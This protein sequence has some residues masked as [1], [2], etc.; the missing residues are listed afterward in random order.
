MPIVV[1]VRFHGV[2]KTYDFDPGNLE[3]RSGDAVIVETA[4]GIEY[5]IAS[6]E[7][8]E[9]PAEKIFG[10]LRPVLR[11][12][13]E[14]DLRIYQ[15]NVVKEGEAYKIA[16]ERIEQHGLDMQLVDV[17]YT[18][19][20]QKIIFYFISEN[21]VDFRELVKDLAITFHRRIELRQI[22]ARDEA[23]MVGGVG[24]CG[25]TFCCS[26]FLDDFVP[27]SVKM[28][29]FQN[30]SMNPTK[31]SGCC[32]RLMCCLKYEQ[33]AYED[34][35]KIAPKQ[36]ST[37]HSPR[38]E[39]RVISV[40][41]LHERANVLVYGP[42]GE[43]IVPF[44]FTELQ[45]QK[46]GHNE[47]LM[48]RRKRGPAKS[49]AQADKQSAP[50]CGNCPS[51]NAKADMQKGA[52]GKAVVGLQ[53][54]ESYTREAMAVISPN[55]DVEIEVFSEATITIEKTDES[56]K[57]RSQRSRSKRRRSSGRKKPEASE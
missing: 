16:R 20:G 14:E 6:F 50:P 29:K 40:D 52:G 4:K 32:G 38:G 11:K 31:I 3:I 33:E 56:G 45:Y 47:I 25:R 41:L 8:S 1:G 55:G 42:N 13:H 48:N 19:D 27:V 44:P 24:I 51:K 30:L 39:G 23:R 9:K 22:G 54:D 34:A 2:G 49:A 7:A 28:A 43:E 26:T 21:R 35:R 17:E 53:I 46:A 57:T 5:G 10:E 15:N 36:G 18:F 12:A 37:V